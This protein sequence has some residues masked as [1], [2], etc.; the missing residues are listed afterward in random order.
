MYVLLAFRSVSSSEEDSEG[1]RIVDGAILTLLTFVL[2]SCG[3]RT[4]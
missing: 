2:K 3:I 1:F 4:L